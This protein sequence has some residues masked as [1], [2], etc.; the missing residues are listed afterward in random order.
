MLIFMLLCSAGWIVSL[1]LAAALFISTAM[2][3]ARLMYASNLLYFPV[4]IVSV[5]TAWGF[6][7]AGQESWARLCMALPL[8]VVMAFL[9]GMVTLALS[10]GRNARR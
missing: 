4:V 2:T 1:L 8:V 7:L 5:I 6:Y 10:G 3:A 9:L